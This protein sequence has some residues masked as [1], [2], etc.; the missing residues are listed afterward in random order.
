M[1]KNKKKIMAVWVMITL[2]ISSTMYKME[3]NAATYSY[4]SDPRQEFWEYLLVDENPYL[5]ARTTVPEAVEQ[6]SIALFESGAMAASIQYSTN[7]YSDLSLV[8]RLARMFYGENAQFTGEQDAVFWVLLNRYYAQSDTF[9]KN[10]NEI[11]IKP[12]QFTALT[13]TQSQTEQAR[14]S[15]AERDG[16]NWYHAIYLACMICTSTSYSYCIDLVPKPT[17]ITSQVNFLS[18][19]TF[20]NST[21]TD[22]VLSNIAVPYVAQYSNKAAAI[23]AINEKETNGLKGHNIFFNVPY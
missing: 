22:A 20:K 12:Q 5:K 13:G 15:Q 16:V 2:V 21:Y 10:I 8:E 23:Q 4:T 14:L 9:G 7:W 18:L 1:R 3:A 11:I 17:Y 6:W 19:N